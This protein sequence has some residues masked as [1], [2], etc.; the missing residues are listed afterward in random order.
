M[1]DFCKKNC[2]Q[3]IATRARQKFCAKTMAEI[4]FQKQ[5]AY[6]SFG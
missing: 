2:T 4:G 5:A 6:L 3:L 1:P